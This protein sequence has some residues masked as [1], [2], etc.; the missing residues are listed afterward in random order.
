[1]MIAMPCPG[2]ERNVKRVS[3][4]GSK[5]CVLI[6]QECAAVEVTGEVSTDATSRSA[7]VAALEEGNKQ[8]EK[9]T[10]KQGAKKKITLPLRAGGR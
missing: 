7:L 4:A 5:R 10:N 8:L 6:M 2:A 9:R 1:M 3:G